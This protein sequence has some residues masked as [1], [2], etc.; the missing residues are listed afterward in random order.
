MLN[1]NKNYRFSV[2]NL[3]VLR[4][5]TGGICVEKRSYLCAAEN[6]DEIANSSVHLMIHAI[7]LT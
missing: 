4:I 2:E 6:I 5:T 7:S 3:K 1:R